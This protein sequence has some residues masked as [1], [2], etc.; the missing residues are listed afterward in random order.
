MFVPC[1]SQCFSIRKLGMFIGDFTQR[2]LRRFASKRDK[3]FEQVWQWLN[4]VVLG[5]FGIV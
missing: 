5:W 2:W 1:E 3:Y 4:M